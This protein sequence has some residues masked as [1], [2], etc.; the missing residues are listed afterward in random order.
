MA[1]VPDHANDL[2]RLHPS[3]ITKSD[4][5]PQGTRAGKQPSCKRLAG[6]GHRL[7][8]RSIECFEDPPFF[9]GDAHGG[10]ITGHGNVDERAHA[11]SRRLRPPLDNDCRFH[12]DVR[13]DERHRDDGAGIEYMRPCADAIQNLLKEHHTLLGRRVAVPRKNLQRHHPL[14]TEAGVGLQ[15]QAEAAQ[16]K[17]GAGHQEQRKSDLGYDDRG[18]QRLAAG[19]GA[20]RGGAT[21]GIDQAAARTVPRREDSNDDGDSG[22][23]RDCEPDNSRIDGDRCQARNARRTEGHNRSNRP[24][25]DKESGCAAECSQEQAFGE[26]LAH[27]PRAPGTHRRTHCEL[28]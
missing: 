15:Q 20:R 10:E 16:E 1:H 5:L 2:R 11:I 7:A 28:P 4:L 25:R 6:H 13:F 24:P 14:R 18:T 12:V 3:L 23:K 21:N 26:Q 17:S 9:P 8:F 27:E 19:A 22:G